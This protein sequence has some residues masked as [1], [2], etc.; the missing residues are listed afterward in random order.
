MKKSQDDYMEPENL[1]LD[2]CTVRVYR[3]IL[4]DEERERR[5]EIIKKAAADFIIA[6]ERTKK[7]SVLGGGK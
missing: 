2:N 7:N 6:A 4:T 1:H 3:P 5:M